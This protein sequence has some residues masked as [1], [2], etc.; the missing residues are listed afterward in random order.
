MHAINRLE[1]EMSADPILQLRW[2]GR[3]APSRRG[4]DPREPRSLGANH[5]VPLFACGRYG[6]VT[7]PV[8]MIEFESASPGWTDNKCIVRLQRQSFEPNLRRLGM[9][10]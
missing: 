8:E 1:F 9:N 10:S 2:I 4:R 6:H 3:G 5:A 7:A